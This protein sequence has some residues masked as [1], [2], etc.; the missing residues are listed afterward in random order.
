[1][2]TCKPR[3]NVT[4]TSTCITRLTVIPCLGTPLSV[5][6]LECQAPEPTDVDE[7]IGTGR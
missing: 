4:S 3:G 2:Y 6:L 7:G 5:T 1:M